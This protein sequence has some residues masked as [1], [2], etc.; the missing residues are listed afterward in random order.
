[1]GQKPMTGFA[2]VVGMTVDAFNEFEGSGEVVRG[3]LNSQSPAVLPQSG[4]SVTKGEPRGQMGHSDSG[5]L[6]VSP[7]NAVIG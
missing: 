2:S 6:G 7:G 1:M 5:S 4:P 3:P